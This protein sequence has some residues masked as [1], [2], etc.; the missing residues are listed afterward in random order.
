MG[1]EHGS[2]QHRERLIPSLDAKRA[3]LYGKGRKRKAA[4]C[5]YCFLIKELAKNTL[6]IQ[7]TVYD[8]FIVFIFPDCKA[9]Q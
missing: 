1:R 3:C 9:K 5:V 6:E 7:K 2:V 4:V 8:L